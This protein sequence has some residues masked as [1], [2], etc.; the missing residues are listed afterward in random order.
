MKFAKKQQ[1]SF[2]IFPAKQKKP[3]PIRREAVDTSM[4]PVK[5]QLLQKYNSISP[6]MRH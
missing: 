3:P 1:F 4:H 2:R 6:L 5:G